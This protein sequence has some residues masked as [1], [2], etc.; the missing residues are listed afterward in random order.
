MQFVNYYRGNFFGKCCSAVFYEL[1]KQLNKITNEIL[2]W[3]I[4]GFTDQILHQKVDL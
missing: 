1:A 4:V 2:W 3:R